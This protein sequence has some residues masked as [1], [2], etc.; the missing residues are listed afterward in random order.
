MRCL[1]VARTNV[2][3]GHIIESMKI[4]TI[5]EKKLVQV[6]PMPIIPESIPGDHDIYMSPCRQSE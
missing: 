1:V 2:H 6:R 3:I 4:K 5:I